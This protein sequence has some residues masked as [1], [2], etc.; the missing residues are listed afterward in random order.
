MPLYILLLGCDNEFLQLNICWRSDLEWEG[1][2]EVGWWMWWPALTRVCHFVMKGFYLLSWFS[3]KFWSIPLPSILIY[4]TVS[5][6]SLLVK[7][8]SCLS[9]SHSVCTSPSYFPLLVLL[10]SILLFVLSKSNNKI[11]HFKSFSIDNPLE[12][13][14]YCACS[15]K[16]L[17]LSIN[18]LCTQISFWLLNSTNSEQQI[19]QGCCHVDMQGAWQQVCQVSLDTLCSC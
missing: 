13:W 17:T 16:L 1:W 2:G 9:F 7:L 14:L 6:V 15:R 4:H 12:G 5:I 8:V 19:I 3:L 11:S 18:F 10:C